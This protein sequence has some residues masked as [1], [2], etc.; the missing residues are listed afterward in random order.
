MQF[1]GWL[2]MARREEYALVLD[3]LPNGRASE[4]TKLPIAQLLGENFFTLLDVVIKPGI[5]LK[6]GDRVYVGRGSRKEVDH[7]RGRISFN[8]LTNS[9]QSQAKDQIRK[10]VLLKEREFVGFLNRAG[11][12]NIRT[13]SLELLPSIGK[14]HLDSIINARESKPFESFEDIHQRVSSLG[15]IEEIFTNRVI[16]ELRGESKYFLFVKPPAANEDDI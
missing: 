2:I 9:A 14:R 8:D 10:L 16:E 6:P 15:K 3:F 5:Y 4:A 13:H 1:R 7:I 11:S 12:L